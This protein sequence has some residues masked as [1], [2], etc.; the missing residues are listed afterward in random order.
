VSLGLYMD[1]NVPAPITQ[2]LR[3]RGLDVLTVQED[4]RGGA[5]DP[6]VLDRATALGRVLMTHDDDFLAEAA[7]RQRDGEE[8]S[9]VI[10]AHQLRVTVGRCIQ[11]LELI[12]T[13]CDP[14]ELRNQVQHLPL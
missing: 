10:Y 9:G 7:R 2:G 8:F 5:G 6:A 13:L 1:E 3:Q 4:G 12:G 14:G 11:E